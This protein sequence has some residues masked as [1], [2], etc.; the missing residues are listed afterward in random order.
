MFAIVFDLDTN[1]LKDVYGGPSWN[2]AYTDVRNF[3]KKRGFDWQQGS[4]YFGDDTVDAVSCVLTIQDMTAEFDWFAPSVRDIRMLRIED[5]NDLMPA[6][7]RVA[8]RRK[9]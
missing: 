9:P 1:S 8:S 5:N 7:A 4:T 3:L 6:V 2:N